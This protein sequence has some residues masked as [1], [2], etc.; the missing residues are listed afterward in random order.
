M[1]KITELMSVVLFFST[2]FH[3]PLTS[4]VPLLCEVVSPVDQASENL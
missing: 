4:N 3:I 1:R 2:G